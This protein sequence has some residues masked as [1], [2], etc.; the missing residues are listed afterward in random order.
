MFNFTS[1][2]I[3]LRVGKTDMRKSINGLS[4]MA[5]DE[6]EQ[7]PLSGD[8]FLFSNRRNLLKILY[9]DKNGF[10][11]WQKRLEKHRFPWPKNT[12]DKIALEITSKELEWL[13]KGIDFFNAHETLFFSQVN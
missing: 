10:C 5:A 2:R 9:W 1:G 4:A 8:L 12:N 3:F 13:L 7:N 11:L 6:L